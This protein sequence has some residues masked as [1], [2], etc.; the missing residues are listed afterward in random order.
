MAQK[1][2]GLLGRLFS[3]A[4]ALG[5]R[6]LEDLLKKGKRIVRDV[7]E[8]VSELEGEGETVNID[9]GSVSDPDAVE[10]G[11]V[12]DGDSVIVDI[13][14]ADTEGVS[15]DVSG[16]SCDPPHGPYTMCAECRR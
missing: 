5:E 8:I 11:M 12:D 16:G 10:V 2:Q 1:K 4:E 3:V 7:E 14:G 9:W 13:P 6:E 15:V